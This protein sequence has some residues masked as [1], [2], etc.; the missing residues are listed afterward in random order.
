MPRVKPLAVD[1]DKEANKQMMCVINTYCF[2]LGITKKELAHR[3]QINESTFYKR[4]SNPNKF[5]REELVRIFKVLQMSE[6][7]KKAI[8]W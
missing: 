3:A 4:C 6:E 8:P 1:K 5:L 7:D 2:K